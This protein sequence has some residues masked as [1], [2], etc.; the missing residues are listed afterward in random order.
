MR[1]DVDGLPHKL[2]EPQYEYIL[3]REF[4][5]QLVQIDLEIEADA[6]SPGISHDHIVP[7]GGGVPAG[8]STNSEA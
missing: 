5:A 6:L 7:E 8:S 2:V 3:S 1:R 4:F